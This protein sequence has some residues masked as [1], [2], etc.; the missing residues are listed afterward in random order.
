MVR[1][2]LKAHKVL[3]AHPFDWPYPKYLI[4]NLS[5]EE[6]EKVSAAK[7]RPFGTY[8]FRKNRNFIRQPIEWVF[9]QDK[10]LTPAKEIKAFSIVYRVS[11]G[12][13]S[14]YYYRVIS[15]PN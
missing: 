13:Y 9:M 1:L 11:S 15:V 12:P 14:G 7:T 4:L 10:L 3:N 2:Y 8:F 6:V 5:T